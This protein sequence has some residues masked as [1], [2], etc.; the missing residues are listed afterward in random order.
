MYAFGYGTDTCIVFLEKS[1][2]K[3]FTCPDKKLAKEYFFAVK[4]VCHLYRINT[5]LSKACLVQKGIIPDPAPME[6]E[7]TEEQKHALWAG[8]VYKS[9]LSWAPYP[10]EVC[11]VTLDRL[12]PPPHYPVAY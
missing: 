11:Q 1:K 3:I 7:P 4:G 5:D 2:G 9:L 12:P 6:I 10:E 8:Y